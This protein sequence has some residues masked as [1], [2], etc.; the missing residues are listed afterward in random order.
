MT[1]LLKDALKPNLVQTLEASPALVHGGP[2]ANIAHGCNSVD[3]DARRRSNSPIT[4][5]PRRASAPISAPRNSSTSS[6]ARPGLSRRRRCSSRRCARSRCTAGSPR[7]RSAPKTCRRSR[8]GLA[9]LARHIANLRKFG[10]PVVVAINRF[11]AD[12]EAELAFVEAAVGDEFQVKTIVCEHWARG[13][14][15]ARIWPTPSP[16]SR[17]AARPIF[18]CFIP[19]R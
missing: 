3:G 14:A 18:V 8:A 2:F 19:T 9:N 15:G 11:N 4:S 12:T 1:A 10:V 6:A 16:V 5:S 17:T 7:T 13:G